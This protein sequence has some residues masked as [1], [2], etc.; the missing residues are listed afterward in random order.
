[1]CAAFIL[2]LKFEGLSLLFDSKTDADSDPEK[3]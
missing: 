1:M 2:L 3:D